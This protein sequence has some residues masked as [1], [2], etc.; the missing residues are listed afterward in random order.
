MFVLRNEELFLNT[1]SHG[2]SSLIPGGN[3]KVLGGGGL[4]P[5]SL[6]VPMPVY[7]NDLGM[8][9]VSS[10]ATSHRIFKHE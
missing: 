5:I 6:P 3:V 7:I 1:C 10:S 4:N 2:R 9:V 8:P